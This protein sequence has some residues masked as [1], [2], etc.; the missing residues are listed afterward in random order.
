MTILLVHRHSPVL[1]M[2]WMRNSGEAVLV[3]DENLK[4][5][6]SKRFEGPIKKYKGMDIVLVPPPPHRLILARSWGSSGGR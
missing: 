1:L 5:E 6:E 4:E 3:V 2:I